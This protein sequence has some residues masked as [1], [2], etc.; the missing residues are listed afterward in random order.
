MN[1]FA[2]YSQ[3]V[4]NTPKKT[5]K[6]KFYRIILNFMLGLIPTPFFFESREIFWNNF[7]KML[8]QLLKLEF[9]YSF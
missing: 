9:C 8:E 3:I 4:V 5:E 2:F 7:P 6:I 1:S